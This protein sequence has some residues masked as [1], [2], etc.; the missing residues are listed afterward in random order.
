MLMRMCRIT[1]TITHPYLHARTRAVLE[2]QQPAGSETSRGN[3]TIPAERI[4]YAVTETRLS[5]QSIELL[6]AVR[7]ALNRVR[8]STH[9]TASLNASSSTTNATGN[10]IGLYLHQSKVNS[11]SSMS[12]T[13]IIHLH[14]LQD[15]PEADQQLTTDMKTQIIQIIKKLSLNRQRCRKS[16][17]NQ[18]IFNCNKLLWTF[19]AIQHSAISS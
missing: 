16:K 13:F 15:P 7:E 9:S 5:L 10:F 19:L 8:K 6:S 14:E 17:T 11:V 18:F 12:T 2:T 4:V 3:L 1:V